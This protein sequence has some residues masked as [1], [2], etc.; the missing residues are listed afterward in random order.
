MKVNCKINSD[1]QNDVKKIDNADKNQ[2][3]VDSED[4]VCRQLYFVPGSITVVEWI[5]FLCSSVCIPLKLIPD[6][7]IPAHLCHH[8]SKHTHS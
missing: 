1:L 2:Q 7:L 6:F 3:R 5:V 4:K 8:I